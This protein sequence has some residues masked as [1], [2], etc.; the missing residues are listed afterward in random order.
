MSATACAEDTFGP[1]GDRLKPRVGRR[2][3]G[4]C[5][6]TPIQQTYFL[7]TSCLVS[8]VEIVSDVPDCLVLMTLL[9]S[10]VSLLF[11]LFFF[12]SAQHD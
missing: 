6:S 8:F 7:L 9:R 12:I 3:F 11:N 2:R 5:F 1:N 10:V 4:D